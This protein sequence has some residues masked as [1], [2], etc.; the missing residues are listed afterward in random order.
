MTSDDSRSPVLGSSPFVRLSTGE[1][2]GSAPTTS[3]KTREGTATTTSSA[4]S[5]GASLDQGGGDSAQVGFSRVARVPSG[6]ADR[7]DLLGVASGQR[8]VV[9]AV[10]EQARERGAPRARPD[11]DGFHSEVTKS[12]ETGTPSSLKRRRS[13]F[14]TQ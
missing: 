1:V 12:I 2:P 11:D 10:A 13:S 4:L 8:H 5:I 7:G 3:P 6:F 14:S 9:A